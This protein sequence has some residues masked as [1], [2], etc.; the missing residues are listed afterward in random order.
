MKDLPEHFFD[1]KLI[2]VFIDMLQEYE[3]KVFTSDDAG[4][5]Y[6]LITIHFP[7]EGITLEDIEQYYNTTNEE[8]DV[9]EHNKALAINY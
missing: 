8:I 7:T 3:M 5:L 6:Y 9:F 2:E 1:Y 4:E